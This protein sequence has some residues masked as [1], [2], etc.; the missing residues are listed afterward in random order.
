M[1]TY[2]ELMRALEQGQRF[3]YVHFWGHTPKRQ[4]SVDA[5]CFSQWFPAPFVVDDVL[6]PT[7]EHYMM[8]R[9]AELFGDKAI[10]EMMLSGADPGKVKALGRQVHGFR[11]ELWNQH[12]FEI[13]VQGNY[14]KFS[15][16]DALKEFLLATNTR[17][18]V[19]SKNSFSASF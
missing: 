14:A 15:Q 16:N 6:F 11:D 7:A 13:V 18:L 19:A 2:K 17:F 10:V 5:S 8:V 3:K 9:K 4:G 1:N 12:R